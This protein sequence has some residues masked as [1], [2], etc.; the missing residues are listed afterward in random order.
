MTELIF[1]KAKTISSS[2]AVFL[3]FRKKCKR[4]VGGLGEATLQKLSK[5]CD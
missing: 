4:K 2:L 5:K 1:S 3:Q